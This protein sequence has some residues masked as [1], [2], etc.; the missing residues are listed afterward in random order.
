MMRKPGSDPTRW[1]SITEWAEAHELTL[2]D[3]LEAG[4]SQDNTGRIHIPDDVWDWLG[5]RIDRLMKEG[6]FMNWPA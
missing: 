3:A 1:E 5:P 6:R 4:V 2:E